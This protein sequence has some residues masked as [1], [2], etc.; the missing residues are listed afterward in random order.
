MDMPQVPST[1]YVKEFS[2]MTPFYSE[3]VLLTKS[4]LESKTSDG[5]S[6]IL[7]L[8]TLYKKDWMN[9]LER[10]G[11]VDDQFIWS[12]AHIQAT[13]MWASLR[14]Q[15]LFRTVEG[16]MYNEAAIRLIAELENVH[17]GLIINQCSLIVI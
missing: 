3:D 8:Q 7:Y 10:R 17:P 5:V 1:Q 2:C 16:M 14:S 9:F 15:T 12:K 13:R 11:L 4:D 6:T